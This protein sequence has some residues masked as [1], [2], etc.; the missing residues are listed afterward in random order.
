MRT[1]IP[2]PASITEEGQ[3]SEIGYPVH[4]HFIEL[5]KMYMKRIIW[6][7]HPEIEVIIINH[8]VAEFYSED[9]EVTL[10]AGQGILINQNVM[11]TVRSSDAKGNCSMYSL[12]FHPS[13]LF[14]YGSTMLSDKYLNPVLCSP[15]LRTML[16]DEKD[17]VSEKLLSKI[18]N[19]IAINMIKKYGYEVA[20]K[21][22]LC[23]FWLTL[24]ENIVVY[25]KNQHSHQLLNPDEARCKEIIRYIEAHYAEKI[26]LDDI[27]EHVH[28]S[29]SECCRCIKR[30][31]HLTP[32]EYLMKYRIFVAA[33][34]IQR[35]DP[36]AASSS[37][38]AF[39]VGFNN[40][41]YF[42][43]V[44]RQY[45]NCTPSEYKKKLMQESSY[46]SLDNNIF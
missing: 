2:N 16:L 34:F 40:A 26:T 44:F 42:N 46:Y 25:D 29:K 7:W 12:C 1:K 31:L 17:P 23:D 15:S 32:I 43:K 36:A 5:S 14:G 37:N 41:S 6:Q 45:L 33:Q 28:V 21:A 27:A 38:L 18:N 9:Y 8:G 10:N 13:F 35:N 19:I 30:T 4:V 39:S 3:G 20:T 22:Q 11:H 24:L